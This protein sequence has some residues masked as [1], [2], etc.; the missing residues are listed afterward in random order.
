VRAIRQPGAVFAILV[1]LVA[2]GFVLLPQLFATHDPFEGV[3]TDRFSPPSGTYWFGTDNLGRDVYSRVVYGAF[4]SLSSA[5]AA[6]LFGVVL[7]AAVGL[8]SGFVGGVLDFVLMRIVDVLIAVPAILLALIVVAALGFG[9]LS[10]ALGVGFG[11]AGSFARVMRSQV[12]RV[13]TSEFVEAARISGVRWPAILLRHILPNTARPVIA[14]AAL[15]LGTAILGVSALSFLGF[16]A[17]PPAPE[18]GALVSAGRDY[19]SLAWWL[20]LVPGI[21]ILVVVLGV[22]RLSKTIGGNE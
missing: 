15:E 16:G 10:I 6:V 2:L 9:P 12:V 8:V 1:V 5:G 7:G 19:V 17:A 21:V 4:L 20:S 14:M 3:A 22:N 13:R 11:T 18:W